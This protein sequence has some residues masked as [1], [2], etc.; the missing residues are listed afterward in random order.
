MKLCPLS[1]DMEQKT[2]ALQMGQEKWGIITE[3]HLRLTAQMSASKVDCSDWY[4]KPNS[5][6]QLSCLSNRLFKFRK[7]PSQKNQK[8]HLHIL[9]VQGKKSSF[10]GF[11]CLLD[12]AK[13]NCYIILPADATACSHTD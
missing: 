12:T 6:C 1:L 4:P 9:Q 3:A 10:T 8:K 5:V 11:L 2:K 7:L 13:Q